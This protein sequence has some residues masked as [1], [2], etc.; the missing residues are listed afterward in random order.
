[1]RARL[2]SLPAHA[3]GQLQSETQE[4]LGELLGELREDE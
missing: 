4:E 2:A 3:F 1:M